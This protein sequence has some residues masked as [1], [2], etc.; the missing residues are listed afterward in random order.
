MGSCPAL[1][2]LSWVG[3]FSPLP[4]FTISAHT[5]QTYELTAFLLPRRDSSLVFLPPSPLPNAAPAAGRSCLPLAPFKLRRLPYPSK[6]ARAPQEPWLQRRPSHSRLL[7]Q[8]ILHRRRTPP[9]TPVRLCPSLPCSAL[10]PLRRRR[11]ADEQRW[12][13]VMPL[14]V[15]YGSGPGGA[16][17]PPA[18]SVNTA[19]R[20]PRQRPTPSI[21]ATPAPASPPVLSVLI[22]S[23]R[24]HAKPMGTPLL[25]P[26]SSPGHRPIAPTRSDAVSNAAELGLADSVARY[27]HVDWKREQHAEPIC[28][29]TMRYI[30]IARPSVLPPDALASYRSHKRPSLSD[31][32]ELVGKG[33]LDTTDDDS[34]LLVRNPTLPPTTPDKPDSMGRA[35]CL[36]NDEPFSCGL[37]A[38]KLVV[39]RPLATLAAR[40]RCAC[41][42]LYWWSCINAG[43]QWWFHHCLKCQAQ[44]TPR[45]TVRWPIVS[46]SLSEGPGVAVSD[47]YTSAPSRSH[48]E[49]TSTSGYSQ[50]PGKP[51]HPLVGVPAQHN[52]GQHP[53]VLYQA[54][55]SCISAVRCI[56]ACYKLQSSQL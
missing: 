17:R 7:Y 47:D 45:L 18:R 8:E 3:S 32:Q 56:Q 38:G 52:L 5:S 54:L 50:Y 26:T 44:R 1:N 28:H 10:Q 49:A 35:A 24:D 6:A 36:L 43:T 2:M 33:R 37:G 40:A 21:A 34:V 13:S 53:A 27:L 12:Q 51:I 14:A 55:K 48:H 46:M 41:W 31:I 19:P 30:S 20:I 16:P 22:P 25:L 42:R 4:H 9:R 15:D 23:D 39:R 29:A 11:R